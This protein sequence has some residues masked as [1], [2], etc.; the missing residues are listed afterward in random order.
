MSKKWLFGGSD[1]NKTQLHRVKNK[2]EA[3]PKTGTLRFDF[4]VNGLTVC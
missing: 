1:K 4:I 3:N 2:S